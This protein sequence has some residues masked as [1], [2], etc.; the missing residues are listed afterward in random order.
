MGITEDIT[1][2]RTSGFQEQAQQTASAGQQAGAKTV[3]DAIDP[4]LEWEQSNLELWIQIA[5][6]VVLILIWREVS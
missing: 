2:R 5:Q 3:G 1:R 6:L 4:L